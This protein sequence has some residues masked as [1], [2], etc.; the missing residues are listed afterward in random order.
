MVNAV[1]RSE[2]VRLTLCCRPKEWLQVAPEYPDVS[3]DRVRIVH[4]HGEALDPLY[5]DAAAFLLFWRPNAYLDFAVPVKMFEALG[6]GLP[7]ITSEDTEAARF[8]EEEGIGWVV[9]NEKELQVLFARLRDRPEE[10]LDMRAHV[11]AVRERHTWQARARTVAEVLTRR[12]RA[13]PTVKV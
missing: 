8:I 4:A 9:K 2:G 7:I 12:H 6:R 3:G 10:I 1:N 11:L 13:A 5:A